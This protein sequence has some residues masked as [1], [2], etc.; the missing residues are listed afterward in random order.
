MA[1]PRPDAVP[2]TNWWIVR[3]GRYLGSIQLRHRLNDFLADVGGQIG[4]G[5]RPSE[6]RKRIA[7]RALRQVL[8]FAGD[9]IELSS[10]LITCDEE[11]VGSRKTIEA[12]GGVLDSV[13]RSDE[14]SRGVGHAGDSLRFWVPTAGSYHGG[15]TSSI[16]QRQPPART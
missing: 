13:R 7:T 15:E 3:D 2:V 9:R 11:N 10:V 5:I 16:C 4:Y 12:C 14:I 8:G 6:R 1:T